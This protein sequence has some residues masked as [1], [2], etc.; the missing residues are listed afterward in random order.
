MTPTSD[1]SNDSATT[2]RDGESTETDTD[3]ERSNLEESDDADDS[4]D[5][6]YAEK[7]E[8]DGKKDGDGDEGKVHK[9]NMPL[10]RRSKGNRF[11]KRLAGVPGHT[12][13]ESVNLGLKNRLRQRP[14]VNTAVNYLVV[15]DSEDES[16]SEDSS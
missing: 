7:K 2:S 12:I 10:V 6:E 13:P 1:G 3:A 16:S 8:D 4:T 15:P 9:Q 5:E 14:S 11:S